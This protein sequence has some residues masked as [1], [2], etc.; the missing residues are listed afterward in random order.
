MNKYENNTI[1]M[2]AI[3]NIL[4]LA[5]ILVTKVK[6]IEII[7]IIQNNIEIMLKASF[8]LRSTISI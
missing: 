5:D 8:I 6:V 1:T 3:N 2:K 7:T 4:N